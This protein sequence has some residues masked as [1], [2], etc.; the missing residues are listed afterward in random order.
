MAVGSWRLVVC[1]VGC[2]LACLLGWLVGWLVAVVDEVVVDVGCSLLA[3]RCLMFVVRGC[4]GGWSS[5][6]VVVPVAATD[7]VAC[8]EGSR[9]AS[10][11]T[12][13][14]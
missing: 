1:L 9:V 7:P 6:L 10:I 11:A 12:T 8:A 5:S 3:V 14:C 2:L 4:C 13:C